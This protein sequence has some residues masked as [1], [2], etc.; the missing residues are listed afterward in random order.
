MS[1]SS[2]YPARR[3]RNAM[4]MGLSV[5]SAAFGLSWLFLILAVLFWKGLSGLSLAVF[6][7]MT[8][9][10]GSSGGL[11]NAIWRLGFKNEVVLLL[12]FRLAKTR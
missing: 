1:A 12:S 3:R 2:F 5:A 11:L 4:W 7:E 10:P 9:P 6:T 8:P